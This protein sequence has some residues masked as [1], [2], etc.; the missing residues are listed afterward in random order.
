MKI[1]LGITGS[2][3]A[4]KA[5]LLT[6]LFVKEGDEVKVIMT[7]SAHDFI[8]PLTLATLSK[9]PVA[10]VLFNKESGVWT[11]HVELGNWADVMLIAPATANTIAK[12][13][14]GFCDN[15]LLSTF[16]SATCSVF[17]APA[18]DRDMYENA[19]TQ[20]NIGILKS[21]NIHIIPPTSGELASGIQGVGR[22]AE[23]EEILNLIKAHY[24]KF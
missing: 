16:L 18:M 21:R 9:N 7:E 15:L 8:T 14:H 2:I 22:M 5:A 17:V 12:M 24:H 20:E 3:A 10:S 4:Y 13:A 1:I 19:A 6:R 11:N 23:P